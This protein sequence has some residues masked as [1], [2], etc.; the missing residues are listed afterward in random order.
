M[1]KILLSILKKSAFLGIILSFSNIFISCSSQTV[2]VSLD[3][4]RY[5]Y[6][7][8]INT[9]NLWLMAHEGT[10]T[11]MMPS[12]PSLTFPNHYT[13]ATGLYPEHHELIHN[14][15]Y[16]RT[17][18][19]EYSVGNDERLNPENYGGDPIW[20]TAE[21]QGKKVG[22]LYWVA[23]EITHPGEKSFM[24]KTWAQTPHITFEQ[25]VDSTIN[26]IGSKKCDLVM[27]Y[28]EEPDATGHHHGP[29][30]L[31][32]KNKVHYLDSL[33]GCL[34]KGLKA[35]PNAK[36]INLIITS[37]HGMASVPASH[38]INPNDYIKKEWYSYLTGNIPSMFYVN[39]D[40]KDPTAKIDSIYNHLSKVPHLYVWR[41]N[42]IPDSLNYSDNTNIGDILVLPEVGWQF[43]TKPHYNGGAHGFAPQ[44]HQMHVPLI[45]IGHD[46]KTKFKNRNIIENVN[47]YPLLCHLLKIN[48]SKCD[49]T[50]ENTQEL[51]R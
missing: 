47:I 17:S 13:L 10:L 51:L 1:S 27:T 18:H 39:N 7:D 2:I 21:R 43:G 46:F 45:A 4:F 5:S 25:R 49:G 19:K 24:K 38:N 50:K 31:E 16:N 48:P 22:V 41:K 12:F 9:P 20:F 26:W 34:Y 11:E 40:I 3:G 30:S 29:H 37:D 32:V 15:Y 28:F 33:M 36:R 35:L 23:N 6:L 44:N 42:E 14:N 8:S